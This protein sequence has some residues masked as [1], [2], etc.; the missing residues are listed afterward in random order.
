MNQALIDNSLLAFSFLIACLMVGLNK[1]RKIGI[2]PAI[3]LLFAPLVI[4]LN[5]WGHNVAVLIINYK[6]YAAGAFQYNFHFYSLILFGTFFILISGLNIDRARKFINGDE[7]QKRTLHWLNGITSALFL[8]MFFINPIAL[9]PVIS[10]AI[11][12]GTIAL[13]GFRRPKNTPIVM[14]SDAQPA[15]VSCIRCTFYSATRTLRSDCPFS[16]RVSQNIYLGKV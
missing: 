16:L 3:L 7:S 2:F 12:S 1:R 11:S 14:S 13:S 15:Q 6:R 5:M 4:F 8:P 9:L 10:S